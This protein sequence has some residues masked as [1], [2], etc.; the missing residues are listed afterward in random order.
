ME[1]DNED[2]ATGKAIMFLRQHFPRHLHKVLT[3]GGEGKNS[4]EF[5]EEFLENLE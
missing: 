4:V 3:E 2:K 5:H 1:D